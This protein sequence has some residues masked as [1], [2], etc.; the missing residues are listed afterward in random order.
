MPKA[1]PKKKEPEKKAEVKH[2][3]AKPAGRPVTGIKEVDI[4]EV[5]T[6]VS[7]K[8]AESTPVSQVVEEVEDPETSTKQQEAITQQNLAEAITTEDAQ[9]IV[10]VRR[11]VSSSRMFFFALLVGI[12]LG[13]VVF[14][15]LIFLDTYKGGFLPTPTPEVT[16]SPSPTREAEID[17][18]IYKVQIL[19]GTGTSGVAKAASDELIAG[20]F[21]E[22][23]TGNAK[24]FGFT[25]TEVQMKKSLPNG[26]FAK[27]QTS[28]KN[29]SVVEVTALPD[30]AV[31]DLIITVGTKKAAQ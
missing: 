15:G 29:Y 12:L 13:A 18:S 1:A 24:E 16:E 11:N 27:V 31:Y 28:L 4:E 23:V 17:V 2:K 26:V 21:K 6:V 14:G 10:S 5:S 9:A 25:D 8:V 7:E 22:V 20:G 30:D 19:N 3:S